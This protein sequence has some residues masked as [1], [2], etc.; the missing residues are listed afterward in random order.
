MSWIGW[1][2]WTSG[3][4][5]VAAS[6]DSVLLDVPEALALK[7]LLFGYAQAA[8]ANDNMN[9]CHV[10]VAMID[11]MLRNGSVIGREWEPKATNW[12]KTPNS[13]QRGSIL[14]GS[15]AERMLRSQWDTHIYTEALSQPTMVN[16]Q[17]TSCRSRGLATMRYGLGF[18]QL[19]DSIVADE[20]PHEAER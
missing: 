18:E 19:A 17:I 4:R 8:S 16:T 6:I 3:T 20:A 2:Q 13:N 15:W 5:A 14:R 7:G 12:T 1:S 9:I 10:M 11:Q